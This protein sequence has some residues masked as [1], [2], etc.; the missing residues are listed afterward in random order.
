MMGNKNLELFKVL[1]DA[2]S[3]AFLKELNCVGERLQNL[4]IFDL[5]NPILG[6]INMFFRL[7]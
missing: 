7:D 1:Y 3:R 6:S 2:A 4:L 5:E